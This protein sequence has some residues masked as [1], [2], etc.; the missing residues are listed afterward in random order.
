MRKWGGTDYLSSRRHPALVVHVARLLL[1]IELDPV[2]EAG[3]LAVLGLTD[4]D[5]LKTGRVTGPVESI[6]SLLA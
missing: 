4:E 6:Q 3:H 1:K 5:M 2:V